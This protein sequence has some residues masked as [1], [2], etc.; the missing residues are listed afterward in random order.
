MALAWYAIQVFV[1]H[2]DKVSAEILRRRRT[3]HCESTIGQTAVPTERVYDTNH[4]RPRW[5]RRKLLPGYVFVAMEFTPH[6]E[7]VIRHTPSVLGFVSVPKIGI[8]RKSVVKDADLQPILPL[9]PDDVARLLPWVTPSP[10]TRFPW[11][12]GDAVMVTHGPFRGYTGQVVTFQPT[13]R[14]VQLSISLRGH[15]T[16]V[17]VGT[18]EIATLP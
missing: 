18:D 14:R 6:T 10:P 17:E 8:T 9:T 16:T 3:E 7:S 11:Q 15:P 5:V 2:E 13:D 12:S 1:G 4:G